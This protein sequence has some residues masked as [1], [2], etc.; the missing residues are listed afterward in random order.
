MADFF[1]DDSKLTA[2]FEALEPKVR[3]RALKNAFRAAARQLRNI[4]ISNL[5]SSSANGKRFKSNREVEK[6]IRQVVWK[7]SLGFRI[8]IGTKK[9]KGTGN[10]RFDLYRIVPLWAEGGTEERYN[11]RT[12]YGRITGRRK[13]VSGRAKYRGRLG[14]YGFMK[15]TLGMT[16]GIETQLKQNI[17]TYVERAAKK[18]GATVN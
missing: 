16:D 12:R 2:L 5:R 14:A 3:V 10:R 7:K 1:Y 4:A 18:A 17:V 6:G 9:K 13:N 8:T 15:K 11:E